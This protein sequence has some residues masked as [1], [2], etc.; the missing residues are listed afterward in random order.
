MDVVAAP[1]L[2][3]STPFTATRYACASFA[4][5]VTVTDGSL[6]DEEFVRRRPRRKARA[7]A[8]RF[9]SAPLEVLE[10]WRPSARSARVRASTRRDT[11]ARVTRSS[12]QHVTATV[13]FPRVYS[14][15]FRTGAHENL[16]AT[17][18]PT[19]A[20]VRSRSTTRARGPSRT[21]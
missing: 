21:A 17:S 16:A 19:V 20:D 11:C 3:T 14:A 5:G 1:P 9:S 7:S 18:S 4:I 12:A 8:E 10:G 13:P 15:P 6:A 2:P